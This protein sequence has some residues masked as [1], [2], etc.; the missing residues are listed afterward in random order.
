M[1]KLEGQTTTS[2]T[3]TTTAK[4][5]KRTAKE[6]VVNDD[7]TLTLVMEKKGQRYPTESAGS[8][9]YVFYDTLY[10]ENPDSVMA[11]VWCIEHGVFSNE[12]AKE[13]HSKYLK[14]KEIYIRR[15]KTG[16]RVGGSSSSSSSSNGGKKKRKLKQVRELS[17]SAGMSVG[18]TE[19]IGTMTF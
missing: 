3:T 15:N 1:V 6:T 10:K 14:A 12:V 13:L 11:L 4:K 18:G 2:T 5:K 19:G 8:G 7:G 9:D 17:G 16:S